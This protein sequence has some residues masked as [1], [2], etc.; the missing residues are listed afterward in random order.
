MEFGEKTGN[1]YVVIVCPKCRQHAQI[2]ETGKKTLRC[3]H[4]GALLQARKLRIFGSF[5]EVPEAV[6]FRTRL[7]AELSGKGKE[8]F[9]LNTLPKKTERSGSE[10]KAVQRIA[11]F[12]EAKTT[13][14]GVSAKKRPENNHE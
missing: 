3:Q 5:E 7:Q 4:C 11:Q 14:E 6:N 9:S 10:D 13:S 12:P 1:R 2:T 8:T